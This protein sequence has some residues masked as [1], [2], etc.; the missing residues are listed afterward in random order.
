MLMRSNLYILHDWVPCMVYIVTECRKETY[1]WVY[2]VT[3]YKGVD[4]QNRQRTTISLL[5][6]EVLTLQEAHWD[7]DI[8]YFVT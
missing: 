1:S 2:K 6:S 7:D 4:I 8:P 3:A 5:S